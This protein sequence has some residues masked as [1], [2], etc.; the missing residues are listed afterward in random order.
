MADVRLRFA[1]SPTG[2]LHVG[3]ARTALFNW[4]LARKQGG[5]FVL[6]IED[7]DVARS[8]Q[9]S[10]DAILQ[11]MEWLGLDWDEGPFYQSER[12]GVYREYVEKLLAAGKAYKC[13]CTAEELEAKREQA[14]REGRKPKYDGTCRHRPDA[15]DAP[16]VVRFK[17]P[18]EGVTAF[19]DLIKGRISFNNEELDDLIIQRS[20]GTPTYNFVVVIDDATMGITTVIRG[21]DH[22]NNTPRQILLYEALG[23]PVPRFAHVPMI[24]GADKTRLSKRHGATSVMAYRDMG[25]LPEAMVNYLVRL[26][27][28]HGDEE[29]FSREELIEKFSIEAV[30]KSAGVFNP[31]K[32]LWL[33]HHY[34]KESTPE[35]L[36]GLLVPFLAERGIDPATGPALAA[37]VKTLQERSRTLIEMADGA[38]FYYRGDFAYDEAAAAKQFTPA[39]AQLMERLAGRLEG[40]EPFGHDAIE[41]TFKEL[42]SEQ[43]IKM[44]QIGPAVRVA[45]CGGTVSPSIYE[46]IEVLGRD[47]TV[48]RIRRAVAFI[49]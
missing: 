43:G 23:Y 47:E 36:A 29:I 42:C 30:G 34:I 6:R 9:E 20:D 7:T 11:G 13:Y 18:Q 15:P 25:F 2:Y 22:V 21:D 10:V 48:R 32:L 35:R 16:Y 44:G 37:V 41:A 31:D 33:N 17:A 38:I 46:V 39:A 40:L 4:L 1:P 49:G 19:D 3:G 45:L 28:S 27:W 12:F 24:L 14:L 5:T 8:T 26:G